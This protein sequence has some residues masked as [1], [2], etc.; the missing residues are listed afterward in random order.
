MNLRQIRQDSND[1]ALLAVRLFLGFIFLW[2]GLP[3]LLGPAAASEKFAGMG[4]PGVLGP[5]VGALEVGAAV[6]ILI[7]YLV[8]LAVI[9]A[10]A[11]IAVA[12]V[13]VQI[14]QGGVHAALER[15]VLILITMVVL[16]SFGPGRYSVGN[17][18]PQ[19][20]LISRRAEG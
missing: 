6:L 7:G 18:L 20:T 16:F 1:F 13:T 19:P 10:F 9:V 17:R 11:I 12:L 8:P 14:P 2:H 3:K 15:D 5:I 4:F